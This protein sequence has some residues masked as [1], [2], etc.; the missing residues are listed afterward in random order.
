MQIQSYYGG[1]DGILTRDPSGQFRVHDT[2]DGAQVDCIF[3]PPLDRKAEAALGCQVNIFGRIRR[4]G[5]TKIDI[6]AT[7]LVVYLPPLDDGL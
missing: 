7:D 3:N 6:E 5:G 2:T 1:I 4:A